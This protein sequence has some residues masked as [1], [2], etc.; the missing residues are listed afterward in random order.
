V[1]STA[2]DGAAEASEP[3]LERLWASVRNAFTS[4]VRVERR[5]GPIV[6]AL[7][8]EEVRLIRRQLSVELQT[9]R[10]ALVGGEAEVFTASLEHAQTLLRADFDLQAGEVESGL[11]LIESLLELDVA[12]QAPDISR[13]LYALRARGAQ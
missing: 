2:E 10:L 8:A 6:A 11:R 9:A 5:D 3:G 12:P 4:I 1:A 13:S 7:T